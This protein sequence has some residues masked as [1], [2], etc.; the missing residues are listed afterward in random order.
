M[1]KE[2]SSIHSKNLHSLSSDGKSIIS[3]RKPE[4]NLNFYSSSSKKSESSRQSLNG[5]SS[6]VTVETSG[7]S[8]SDE[9]VE[10]V[11]GNVCTCGIF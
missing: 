6:M 4:E 5:F 10:P 2:Y 9:V 1:I 7:G 3:H 11:T 8:C